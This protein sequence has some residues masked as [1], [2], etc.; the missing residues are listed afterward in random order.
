MI[1]RAIR[2]GVISWGRDGL[3]VAINLEIVEEALDLLSRLSWGET[4]FVLPLGVEVNER[5]VWA[6][7]VDFAQPSELGELVVG[8]PHIGLVA[9]NLERVNSGFYFPGWGMTH[10]FLCDRFQLG[11]WNRMNE[12]VQDGYVK[13]SCCPTNKAFEVGFANGADRID[14]CGAT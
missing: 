14:V 4:P 8:E 7:T 2:L 10:V 1:I 12:F 5:A 6:E 9:L 3:L 13:V 11:C